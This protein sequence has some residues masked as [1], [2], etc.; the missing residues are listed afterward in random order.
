MYVWL[1]VVQISFNVSMCIW[2]LHIHMSSCAV[3]T[4]MKKYPIHRQFMSDLAKNG[5]W[6]SL[7]HILSRF[8]VK[9]ESMFVLNLSLMWLKNVQK[10]KTWKNNSLIKDIG[11]DYLFCLYIIIN[12]PN[13]PVYLV[14][15][16][17]TEKVNLYSQQ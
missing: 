14:Y 11:I 4:W 12:N 3:S 7:E 16:L 17:Y 15:P 8:G 6:L 10:K 9:S 13:C 1:C 2:C 5:N